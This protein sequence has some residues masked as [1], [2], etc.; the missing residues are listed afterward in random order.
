MCHLLSVERVFVLRLSVCKLGWCEEKRERTRADL[1]V[2]PETVACLW[3]AACFHG[4][5]VCSENMFAP[6]PDVKLWH[7]TLF[8]AAG[9]VTVSSSST[10]IQKVERVP[11]TKYT[12]QETRP[13]FSAK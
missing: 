13:I 1:E 11:L 12:E 2:Q 5:M 10:G 4:K 3:L 6:C 9:K 7:L 8:L